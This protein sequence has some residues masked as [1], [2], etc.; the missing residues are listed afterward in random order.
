MNSLKIDL[1]MVAK[2]LREQWAELRFQNPDLR[3]LE[4]AEKLGVTEAELVA[5]R[6]GY[7]VT[8][9]AEDSIADIYLTLPEVGPITALSQN[10]ACIHENN[11]S[12]KTIHRN[13]NLINIGADNLNL[14][15]YIGCFSYAF[16]VI[17][18]SH[19]KMLES[20]QF[21]DA[22]G[23]AVHKI[24]RQPNTNQKLWNRLINTFTAWDQVPFIIIRAGQ[25]QALDLTL[26]Q[27]IKKSELSSMADNSTAEYLLYKLSTSSLP[28]MIQTN[29]DGLLQINSGSICNV[30][31]MGCWLNILDNDFNLHLRYD[32]IDKT[33]VSKQKT[34]NGSITSIDL[35]DKSGRQI[36]RFFGGG[37]FSSLSDWTK[38]ADSM[39]TPGY[40]MS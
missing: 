17:E 9:L 8:R 19:G 10:C 13:R 4:L 2:N 1:L 27:Q 7:G 36:V 25:R 38:L 15:A 39:A 16:A 28:V 26:R 40:I 11:A 37:N 31:K 21:F 29:T 20:I 6:V 34:I 24:Y 22:Y 33:I 30:K 23:R 18:E 35:Y 12:F 14:Q 5:C 32:L 3:P